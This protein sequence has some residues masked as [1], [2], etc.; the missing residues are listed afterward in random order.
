M[1][2]KH[3]L[4][5]TALS[6]L[7]VIAFTR[8]GIGLGATSLQTTIVNMNLENVAN[9]DAAQNGSGTHQLLNAMANKYAP[10]RN[11]SKLS[12]VCIGTTAEPY[13]QAAIE[14]YQQFLDVSRQNGQL[15][16]AHDEA[17]AYKGGY[18]GGHSNG[19]SGDNGGSAGANGNGVAGAPP[20]SAH[21]K[22]EIMAQLVATMCEANYKPFEAMLNCGDYHRLQATSI[23]VWPSPMVGISFHVSAHFL[24]YSSVQNRS[25][26]PPPLSY[27][28]QPYTEDGHDMAKTISRTLHICGF[29]PLNDIGSPMSIS[30]HLIMPNETA[31]SK[32]PSDGALDAD[33]LENGIKAFYTKHDDDD[34][35]EPSKPTEES[36]LILLHAALKLENLAAVVLLEDDWYGF[37]HA[38]SDSKRKVN[39]Q[40]MI[41]PPGELPSSQSRSLAAEMANK[42]HVSRLMNGQAVRISRG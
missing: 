26:A 22:G 15:F 35:A 32:S 42:W 21:W 13:F 40:L 11:I 31:R 7:K 34:G 14:V 16:V 12:F 27:C 24:L 19:D 4:T 37:L 17:D 36:A 3:T 9:S 29:I 38:Y 5:A 23:L 30:R 20:A 1:H 25:I 8:C 39:M 10:N 28:A 33:N 6:M 18:N 2:H 41:L